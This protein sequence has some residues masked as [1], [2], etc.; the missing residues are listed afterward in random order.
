MPQLQSALT[1]T[2]FCA[3]YQIN[4]A[5]YYRNIKLGRMPAFIKVGGSTHILAEDEQAWIAK[6]RQAGLQQG[7]VR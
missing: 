7:A 6:Q 5:T 3:K 2:D 4:R 1:I